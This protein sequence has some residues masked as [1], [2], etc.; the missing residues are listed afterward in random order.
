[1]VKHCALTPRHWQADTKPYT[2]TLRNY[3]TRRA[4]RHKA[5]NES[6]HTSVMVNRDPHG[7]TMEQGA[8]PRRRPLDTFGTRTTNSMASPNGS[9]KTRSEGDRRYRPIL[10]YLS[11][12]RKQHKQQPL[13]MINLPNTAREIHVTSQDVA[14]NLAMAQRIH[15]QHAR[16]STPGSPIRWELTSHQPTYM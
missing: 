15:V 5:H 9:H 11:R 8:I 10:V 14:L 1:M 16:R 7:R 13:R 12:R 6:G 2:R 4:R 3:P